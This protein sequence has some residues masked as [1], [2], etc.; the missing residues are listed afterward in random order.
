[1]ATETH[2]DS[3][4]TAV[5][6]MGLPG[7]GKSTVMNDRFDLSEWTLIDPDV[8]KQEH[9][10]YDPTRPELI[11]E[12]SKKQAA[13]R[14][15]QA[16][17]D[18]DDIIID[19]TGTNAEKMVRWTQDLQSDGYRVELLYVRVSLPTAI[20]RNAAR[21]RTVPEDI[22]REKAGLISTSFEITARYVDT[23]TVVDND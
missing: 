20:A 6:T 4:P 23:I 13:A 3:R 8:I 11:H 17:A 22:V 19:G 14:Q 15:A 18:G 10:D 5:L 16:V 2:T 12:W 1:M 9:P 21:P 7:A